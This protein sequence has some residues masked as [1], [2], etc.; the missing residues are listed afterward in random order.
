[1]AVS[2]RELSVRQLVVVRSQARARNLRRARVNTEV[3]RY[4]RYKTAMVRL[5]TCIFD[6]MEWGKWGIQRESS[7]IR[8]DGQPSQQ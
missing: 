5:L 8:P 6:S 2:A 7:A 4:D 3:Y 1:M